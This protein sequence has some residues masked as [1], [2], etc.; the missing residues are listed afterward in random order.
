MS[1][2]ELTPEARGFGFVRSKVHVRGSGGRAAPLG[3]ARCAGESLEAAQPLAVAL[4]FLLQVHVAPPTGAYGPRVPRFARR[5]WWLGA[6]HAVIEWVPTGTF[7]PNPRHAGT[8][9]QRFATRPVTASSARWRENFGTLVCGWIPPIVSSSPYA[10]VPPRIRV[11]LNETIACAF[12]VALC[13]L[14][15]GRKYEP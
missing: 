3:P 15:K 2:C 14:R 8:P 1:V 4:Q 7:M 6:P 11:S 5:S 9:A 10:R 12:S 13:R